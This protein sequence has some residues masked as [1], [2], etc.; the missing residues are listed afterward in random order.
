MSAKE[1]EITENSV[2]DLARRASDAA[3]ILAALPN[4]MRRDALLAVADSLIEHNAQILEANE[5]DCD[6]ARVQ[7]EKGEM[8]QSL[9]ARLAD[10]AATL[11][12]SRSWNDR[13][14]TVARR[15]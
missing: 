2:T 15:L 6:L 7:V 3:R 12:S 4:A 9:F 14:V 11:A 1:I 10:T 8:S 13:R 5:R